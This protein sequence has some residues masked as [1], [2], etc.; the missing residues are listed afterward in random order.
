MITIFGLNLIGIAGILAF[1]LFFTSD[2]VLMAKTKYARYHHKLAYGAM[3]AGIL[4]ILF[5]ILGRIFEI[6]I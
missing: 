6:W 2:I 3:A 4:H 5:I 1:I